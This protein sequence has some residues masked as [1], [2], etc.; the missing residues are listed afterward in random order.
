VGANK[1]NKFF[2]CYRQ[3]SFPIT[4]NLKLKAMHKTLRISLWTVGILFVVIATGA[5]Y[6]KTFLPKI[7]TTNIKIV[8][9]PE[10]I[11]RGKYLANNVAGCIDCHSTRDWSK[12]AGP[13]KPGTEGMG[14]EIF[15]QKVGFPGTFIAPNITP[16]HLKDWTDGEIY[17]AITCGV[18]KKGDPLFPV[19][20]YLS[21]GKMSKED[22]YSIISYIKTLPSINNVTTM[23][24]ADFPMNFIL[25]LI[26]QPANP[27]TKPAK[28]DSLQ[29]GKY[30][31]NAASCI[32]CHT[33]F[34]KGQLVT[35][36]AFAGG[37][38]FPM[39]FG[40]L[41]SPNITPDKETGIGTWSKSMF[42]ARFKAHLNKPNDSIP[43]IHPNEFNSIM[44]WTVYAGMNDDDLAAVYTY[45][46]SLKPIKNK[47]DRVKMN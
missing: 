22:I 28:S 15:D 30:I 1:Q 42:I 11:E 24:K 14:G 47:I 31:V 16:F 37:R 45:L 12:F 9:T 44:P 41:T 35:E 4:I 10:R 18:N 3:N 36:M 43:A 39:T 34:E 17:R 19:M 20:P 8:A 2:Y 13:I 21:Y 33:R 38:E 5:F 40:L 23:S 26:P 6:V 27:G 46:N 32:D 7:P 25:Q 29:Y